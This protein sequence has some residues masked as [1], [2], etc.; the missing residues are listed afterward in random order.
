V[1]GGERLHPP[2]PILAC[3][4]RQIRARMQTFQLRGISVSPVL[5]PAPRFAAADE[6]IE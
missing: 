6:V 1:H 4:F 5:H 3:S 2:A